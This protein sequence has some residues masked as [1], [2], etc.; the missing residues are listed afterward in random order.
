MYNISNKNERIYMSGE[1]IQLG[2]DDVYIL[3]TSF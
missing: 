2:N 1:S 3:N